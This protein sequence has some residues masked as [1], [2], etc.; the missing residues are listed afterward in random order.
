MIEE[1]YE[2]CSFECACYDGAFCMNCG[3]LEEKHK[4]KEDCHYNG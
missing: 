2:Y 1:L 3:V 4:H